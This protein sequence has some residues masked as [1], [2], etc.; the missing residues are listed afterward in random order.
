MMPLENSRSRKLHWSQPASAWLPDRR[1][2]QDYPSRPIKIVVGFPAGGGV[3]TS[4]RVVGEA[5]SRG[6]GQSVV[7]ENKPGAAGTIGAAEVAR[8]APDGYTL[9]RHAR[10]PCD[11][12]RDVQVAAVRHREQLRLDFEHR[13]PP[14]HSSWCR[15]I[16]SSR[17]SSDLIAKAKAAPG[18]VTFGSAG[19][20]THASSWHRTARAALPGRSSCT[21]PIAATRR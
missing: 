10:R 3:D 11:L 7:I 15:P 20:G 12:R 19:P 2:R 9:A 14:V 17:R 18:T 8:S 5:L 13:H 1:S 6:L 21:C 4:A 16:P